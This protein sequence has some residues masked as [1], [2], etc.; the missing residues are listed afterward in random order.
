M[1][2][3]EFVVN[4]EMSGADWR[5]LGPGT[6]EVGPQLYEGLQGYMALRRLAKEIAD[7]AE[8][9]VRGSTG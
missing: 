6:F 8:E 5:Q 1:D 9:Y 2:S 7:A 4:P 3:V